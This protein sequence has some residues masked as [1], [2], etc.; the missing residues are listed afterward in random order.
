MRR[1]LTCVAVALVVA[2]GAS[3]LALV[4]SA[5]AGEPSLTVFRRL[6]TSP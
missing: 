6:G 1:R 2:L 3:L 4:P 5:G